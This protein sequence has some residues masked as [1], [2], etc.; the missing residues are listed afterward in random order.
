M[1]LI[2][3]VWHAIRRYDLLPS[4]TR[5]AV[6]VSGGADSVALLSVLLELAPRGGFSVAGIVHVNH[7]LRGA[8]S[9][10]DQAFCEGLAVRQNLPAHVERTD[11]LRVAAA[12]RLST[13]VAAR[14]LRYAALERGR[15]ALGAD[16]VAVGHT[17]DDQAET[18]LLRLLRG[19]GPRGLAGIYPRNGAIVRPMF[20]VGRQQLRAWSADNGITHV[21][22]ASNQDLANPRNLL[23]HEV[24]PALRA[25]LGPSVP[26]A[27]ARA[28]DVA[29]AD[30]E[31][32]A[33]LT[34]ALVRR[35]VSRDGEQVRVDVPGAALAPVAL[36]RRVLLEALRRAGVREPGFAEVEA[37]AAMVQDE[38]APGVDLPGHVRADRNGHAVVLRD[39]APQRELV[40]PFRYALPVPGRVW[41][42]EVSATVHAETGSP[43]GPLPEGTLDAPVAVV[44]S[45]QVTGGLFVRNWRPGDV[46]RPIGLG[47]TKKLQDLFVDRKVPRV[48]RHRLPLVVDGH[49]RVV[50]VPGHALDE[51]YRAS[52]GGSG[53]VVLKLTRQWGGSE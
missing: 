6:A 38:A 42:A 51:V 40:A 14:R 15:Q 36:R 24:L 10:R 19:A 45:A 34:D 20:D 35:L 39:R 18:V 23:R 46:L 33:E 13:E 50:W 52:A 4:G 16:R 32:L 17:R 8:E 37:L 31:L 28:A 11:V 41:I 9:E 2:D 49:D 21:E 29:R 48:V 22:D 43:D 53:V 25:W 27:L 7:Q 30:E 44:A 12:E 1:S 3:G 5:V 47:G 26:A